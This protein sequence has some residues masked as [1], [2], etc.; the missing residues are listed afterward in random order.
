MHA[1]REKGCRKNGFPDVRAFPGP[2]PG[3]AERAIGFPGHNLFLKVTGIDSYYP[4][5]P[6]I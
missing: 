2:I 5:E 3:T 6:A 1:E 4:I